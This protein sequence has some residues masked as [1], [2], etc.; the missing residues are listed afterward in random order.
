MNTIKI[1]LLDDGTTARIDKDFAVYKNSY[2]NVLIDIYVPKSILKLNLGYTH[3]VKIGAERTAE[4]G[5]ETTIKSYYVDYKTTETI[6]NVEYYVFERLLPREF[7]EIAGNE[8]IITN[9]VLFGNSSLSEIITSEIVNFNVQDSN[10]IL[11]DEIEDDDTIAEIE[12]DIT[13][14]QERVG[15]SETDITEIQG[16]VATNT[17]NIAT[18]TADIEH[19]KEAIGISETY[20]GQMT[21]LTLPT[22]T[23]LN[24]FVDSV[25]ERLPRNGDVIIFIQTISGVTDKNFKYI[26]SEF[27]GWNYY[28]LPPMETAYNGS[29]GLVKGSY[30]VGVT[31]NVLIDINAGEFTNIYVKNLTNSNY[32]TLDTFLNSLYEEQ[33]G[34]KNGTIAVGLAN[35]AVNDENG[36]NIANT[37][38]TKNAGATKEFVK[39]YSLPKEFY[40]TYF[41]EADGYTDK[42][43]TEPVSG[44]QF[45]KQTS[46]VGEFEIFNIYRTN[47]SK[48]RLTAKNSSSTTIYISANQNTTIQLKLLNYIKKPNENAQT[49][50]VELSNELE[51]TSG[52]IYKVDFQSNFNDLD[53]VFD[54]DE[55]DIVGQV[56][57]VITQDIATTTYSIYSNEVYPSSQTMNVQSLVVVTQ[58]G[59]LGEIP[60]YDLTGVIDDENITFD[61][62]NEVIYRNTLARFILRVSEQT[63]LPTTDTLNLVYG[64][65][66]VRIATPYNYLSGDATIDNLSQTNITFDAVNGTVID[67]VG[68]INIDSGDNIT[69]IV[70]EDDLTNLRDFYYCTYGTTTYNEISQAVSAGKLPVC[71]YGDILY[72]YSYKAP[73]LQGVPMIYFTELHSDRGMITSKSLVVNQSDNWFETNV[74]LQTYINADNKLNAD[75]VNDANSAKKFVSSTDISNWN[76]KS[77]VSVS[78]TGT[79]TDEVEYITINGVEKKLKGGAG[80]IATWGGITGTL[81]NQTDLKNALNGKQDTLIAGSNITIQNNVISSTASGTTINNHYNLPIGSVFASSVKLTDAW[82]HLLDGSTISQQGTYADFSTW[83]HTQITA[84]NVPTCTNAEFETDVTNTGS[85]GKFVVDDTNLTIRLPKI[86]TFIQGTNT[87]AD[88]GNAKEA[89]LPNIK[90]SFGDNFVGQNYN[91]QKTGAFN[92]S[93]SILNKQYTASSGNI[94]GFANIFFDASHSN[95]IYSNSNTVQPPSVEYPYYIVLANQTKTPVEI[96]INEYQSDL[97]AIQGEFSSLQSIV[98]GMANSPNY[99]LNEIATNGTWIDGKRIYRRVFAFNTS[100]GTTIPPNTWTAVLNIPNLPIDRIVKS[101]AISNDEYNPSEMNYFTVAYDRTINNGSFK[102]IHSR[103]ITVGIAVNSWIVIEYTK[104]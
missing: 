75:F 68:F 79:A 76:A 24:N 67:F 52:S 38:L 15:Q 83:L 80:G 2:R 93:S 28:E 96:D 82:V 21:G 61:F 39:D 57:S 103:N 7:V 34:I 20:I 63:Q 46:A 88:I 101:F 6:A 26:Y 87:D 64:S 5:A 69:V 100:G 74:R 59:N 8:T 13:D 92:P 27:T 30:N 48:M 72:K 4:N 56:L 3:S 47:N 18:N 50:S 41:I 78:S 22:I 94:A 85:C 60:V 66:N 84:G 25:V 44:V 49:L 14:L 16:Q 89:G 33:Q 35:K 43:P 31:R 104:V 91:N 1:T 71:K 86:T 62:G 95:S 45:T 12:A 42:P 10:Y 77:T 11:D 90:G 58:Q 51:L 19:L 17:E 97:S 81:S 65:Q 98:D 54:A 102:L 99:S 36:N 23:Q 37:Y 32:V 53:N 9:V 73:S 70:N 55:N 40:Q 29:L